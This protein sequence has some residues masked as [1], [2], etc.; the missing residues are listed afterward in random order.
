[1]SRS[2]LTQD[3]GDQAATEYG[4]QTPERELPAHVMTTG[5]YKQARIRLG[6]LSDSG[7][8]ANDDAKLI[9]RSGGF[10]TNMYFNAITAIGI[11]GVDVDFVRNDT[12]A[13]SGP[14]V[15]AQL[16][17]A[18]AGDWST[19]AVD[20]AVGANDLQLTLAAALAAGEDVVIYI[21]YLDAP[22]QA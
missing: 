11:G 1:M 14:A 3:N 5:I 15:A 21:E 2:I 12:G 19:V 16:A 6:D 20:A 13:A 9:L 7:Y 17:S 10:I 18:S 8:V 22:V 4:P